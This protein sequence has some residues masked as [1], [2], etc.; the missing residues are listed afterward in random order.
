M[1]RKIT[2]TDISKIKGQMIAIDKAALSKLPPPLD[3]PADEPGVRQLT[4]EQKTRFD[5]SLDGVSAI[6]LTKPQ[7][8]QEEEEFVRKFLTGLKKLLSKKDNWT[9]LQPLMLSLENCAKCQN[10]SDACPVF[11]ESGGQE[12]YRPTYRSEILRRIINKYVKKEGKLLSKFTGSDIE[13]NY[14]TIARLA[15][16][17]YRCT[18]CRRCAQSCPIGVDNGLIRMNCANCSARKWA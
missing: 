13:L 8:K 16:L 10:C 9:F 6:G 1:K 18:L 12:I 4:D 2:L 17:A 5:T 7:N 14:Q 15:E 3:D 11:T